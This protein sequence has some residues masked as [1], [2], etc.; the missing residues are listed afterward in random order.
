MAAFF[1]A[2]LFFSSPAQAAEWRRTVILKDG[3]WTCKPGNQTSCGRV[4]YR[5]DNVQYGYSY[6]DSEPLSEESLVRSGKFWEGDFP[7]YDPNLPHQ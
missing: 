4:F 6:Q 5:C 7:E 2:I 3:E 1:S